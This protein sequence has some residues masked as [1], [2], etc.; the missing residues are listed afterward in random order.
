MQQGGRRY[1]FNGFNGTFFFFRRLFCAE[2][3]NEQCL[4]ENFIFVIS[5]YFGHKRIQAYSMP[6][7]RSGLCR[8]G[9]HDKTLQIRVRTRA[10]ISVSLLRRSQQT[11]FIHPGAREEA[12]SG[13]TRLRTG[14]PVLDFT[15]NSKFFETFDYLRCSCDTALKIIGS[16]LQVQICNSQGKK[17]F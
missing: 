11:D 8:Q 1:Q 7:V 12:S 17:I 13:K 5:S 6:E 3:A 16:N 10:K 4:R 14:Y 9:Q 15:D 2:K